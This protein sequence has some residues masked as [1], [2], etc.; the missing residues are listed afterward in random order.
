M[1]EYKN[2]NIYRTGILLKDHGTWSEYEITQYDDNGVFLVKTIECVSDYP[3]ESIS[4][5]PVLNTY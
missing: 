3:R 4:V 5:G 1:I 2:R